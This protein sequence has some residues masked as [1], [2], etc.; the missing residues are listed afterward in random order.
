M[1][2]N[3]T[4]YNF[5]HCLKINSPKCSTGH[6]FRKGGVPAFGSHC[7]F[8]RLR[9]DIFCFFPFQD[10][11]LRSIW[12]TPQ[13]T[14]V[15]FTVEKQKHCTTMYRQTI[16]YSKF[17]KPTMWF[18]DALWRLCGRMMLACIFFRQ[19]L[20]RPFSWDI[21]TSRSGTF[22]NF[23]MRSFQVPWERPHTYILSGSF[24][25]ATYQ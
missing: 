16:V 11:T 19:Y 6:D 22:T 1:R 7:K 24:R 2:T 18:S 9:P 10:D 4:S 3:T 23:Q 25:N 21:T 5:S 13:K 20:G 17:Y 15:Y 14:D 8:Y 12:R